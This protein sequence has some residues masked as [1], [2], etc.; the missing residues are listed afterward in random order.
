VYDAL[1][2]SR[3]SAVKGAA[4]FQPGKRFCIKVETITCLA[5]FAASFLSRRASV[6]CSE[7]KRWL[8]NCQRSLEWFL[9]QDQVSLIGMFLMRF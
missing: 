9:A 5:I 3:Q 2:W 6:Y 8:R 4:W 7:P 1:D